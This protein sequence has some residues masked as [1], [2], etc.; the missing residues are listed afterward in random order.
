MSQRNHVDTVHGQGGEFKPAKDMLTFEIV[1]EISSISKAGYTMDYFVESCR[2]EA[3][4]AA[5]KAELER[6]KDEKSY[7]ELDSGDPDVLILKETSASDSNLLSEFNNSIQK[8]MSPGDQVILISADTE[9]LRHYSDGD[10]IAVGH[11]EERRF[12]LERERF[13]IN[14]TLKADTRLK[15]RRIDPNDLPRW[16][17]AVYSEDYVSRPE[18]S[19]VDFDSYK[20]D[21]S[22]LGTNGDLAKFIDDHKHSSIMVRL[23]NGR[24]LHLPTVNFQP[25]RKQLLDEVIASSLK[26]AKVAVTW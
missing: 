5:L 8:N 19:E 18:V 26:P 22:R 6:R 20:Y 12:I 1:N 10:S 3:R 9:E 7:V 14:G 21:R 23:L 11:G 25:D 17:L 2:A 15:W 16:D 13:P 4:S 24:V